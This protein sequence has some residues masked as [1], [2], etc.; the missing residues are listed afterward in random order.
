V[1]TATRE[2]DSNHIKMEIKEKGGYFR[3]AGYAKLSAEQEGP[4]RLV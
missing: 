3:N 2:C 4:R 1:T